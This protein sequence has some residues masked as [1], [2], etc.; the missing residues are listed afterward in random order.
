MRI[1]ALINRAHESALL[2]YATHL[3]FWAHEESAKGYSEWLA[4]VSF[5]CLLLVLLDR[6]ELVQ[7]TRP[8]VSASDV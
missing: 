1:W 6:E 7:V 8:S 5:Y 3:L 4:W 2:T